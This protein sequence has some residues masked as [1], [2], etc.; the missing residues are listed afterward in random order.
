MNTQNDEQNN[1]QRGSGFGATS[2]GRPQGE[3]MVEQVK[4]KVQELSG[5]AGEQFTSGL[6]R[7]KVRTADTLRDVAQ[8]LRQS[9]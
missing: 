7:G 9:S 4:D 8:S 6:N 1:F 5:E 3:G 2:S